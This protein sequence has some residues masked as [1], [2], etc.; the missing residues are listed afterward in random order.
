[1]LALRSSPAGGAISSISQPAHLTGVVLVVGTLLVLPTGG[2]AQQLH[3]L[4]SG[5][6]VSPRPEE[7][8]LKL[9]QDAESGDVE[10]QLL[11]GM[12]YLQ[13]RRDA[14]D[15]GWVGP[16]PVEAAKW[17][18]MAA[19]Q[20]HPLGIMRIRMAYYLGQGVPRDGV[21]AQKWGIIGAALASTDNEREAFRTT[22]MTIAEEMHLTPEQ[23]ADADRR[24]RDWLEAFKKRK[25]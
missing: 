4:P 19:E 2:Y 25:K 6:A 15:P 1:M 21:E 11:L 10:A 14:P 18:R 12:R 9:R 7:S 24:A 13:N 22:S 8:T 5:S 16:D 20:G 17:F 23:K 3:R